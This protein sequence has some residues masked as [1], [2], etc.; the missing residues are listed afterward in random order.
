MIRVTHTITPGTLIF[1]SVMVM[2]LTA[3]G[4]ISTA[5]ER[6]TTQENIPPTTNSSSTPT[7]TP[8]T[9]DTDI[10]VINDAIARYYT[11]YSQWP[12]ANG[13]T[14]D[15]EWSKLVPVYLTATPS[16]DAKCNWYVNSR[17]NACRHG[18]S[19][20]CKGGEACQ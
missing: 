17:G 6:S 10:A 9:Y 4:G 19:C 20:G 16:T 5:C 18:C 11:N 2:I 8:S 12:T 1:A 13:T 14:G 15:I 7:S 3:I